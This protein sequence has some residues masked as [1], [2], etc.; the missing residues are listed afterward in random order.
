MA[1][2]IIDVDSISNSQIKNNI[3][4]F[5]AS[6]PDADKWSQFFAASSGQLTV[7]MLA[8]LAAF[9]KY[10]SISSRRENYL[11]YAQTRGGIVAGSQT[12]GY[13]AYR[14]RNALL[15]VTFTPS[16]STTLAKWHV[17]G[18]VAGFSLV[19]LDEI[20]VNAGVPVTVQCVV[21]DIAEQD[22]Q[23]T[24]DKSATFRF[25]DKRVSED[26]QI[27]IGTS[28]VPHS[29]DIL[30]MLTD[31]FFIQTNAI[32][33]VDAKYLNQ[34]SALPLKYSNGSI[35]KLQWVELKDISFTTSDLALDESEGVL[36]AVTVTELFQ[37]PETNSSIKTNA[38][39]QNETKFTIRGRNDYSKL[40]LL[41]DP[42]FVAAGGRDTAVAA[43]VEIFAVRDDLS[44]PDSI[45]KQALLDAVTANRPFGVQP[46]IIIDPIPNFLEV[47]VILDLESG[48]VGDTDA[49]VRGI[50][51]EYEKKLSTPEEIQ[52]VDFKQI[53]KDMTG[54]ELVIISRIL[55]KY[56]TWL[57][58]TSYKR[59]NSVEPTA[60]NGFIYEAINFV[61]YSGSVEPTWP[62][63]IPQTL[64]LTGFIYGQTVVDNGIVW[65][66]IAEDNVLTEWVADSV[67]RVGTK[68]KH[69]S[70][71]G[72]DPQ[73]SF[74]VRE[75][76]SKSGLSTPAVF[77][78]KLEQTVTFTADVIG[79]NGNIIN[80]IFDGV[81]DI[82]TVTG[83]W[84]SSNPSN[85]VSFTGLGNVVLTVITFNLENGVDA[86]DAE[87]VW[88]I[89]LIDAPNPDPQIFTDDNQILWLMVE[90]SGTPA[91]WI[92]DTVYSSG[93]VVVPTTPLAGHAGIMFQMVNT[94]GKTGSS[95]PAFPISFGDT[96]I[97]NEVEWVTRNKL[98]SPESPLS[99]EYYLINENITLN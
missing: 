96:I 29:N 52:K 70:T 50:L 16:T 71:G 89:P 45:E 4:A 84:N 81:D 9:L 46:P 44:I 88:P 75:V 15:D 74:F 22:I 25:S 26:V 60:P 7:E 58:N 91:A 61:R 72:N 6:R 32:G 34:E 92:T 28:V 67:Y 35:I 48:I 12:L 97:D 51:A 90:E 39:L 68:V 53:E 17:L 55:V 69:T 40:L 14:G 79:V 18:D 93:D 21:G 77:A 23:S 33:S 63:P 42:D 83:T 36:S 54:S 31:H 94:I 2:F 86:F 85:P 65:E 66:S 24:S 37:T 13:S 8:G 20:V 98:G 43:V 87:P 11:P 19:L 47:D 82:D 10:D 59:G 1:E 76:L 3:E 56:L 64:P 5:I 57:G 27:F 95:E 73:A 99:N 78:S 41:A 80:L 49:L 38:P 30:D 62:A